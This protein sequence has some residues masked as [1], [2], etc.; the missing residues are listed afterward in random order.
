MTYNIQPQLDGGFYSACTRRM[1][2]LQ[3]SGLLPPEEGNRR[4]SRKTIFFDPYRYNKVTAC[5]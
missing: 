4:N 5:L 3:D 2:I 1:D